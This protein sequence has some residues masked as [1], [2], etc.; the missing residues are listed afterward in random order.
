MA[1]TSFGL[2]AAHPLL[3]LIGLS[4]CDAD[5]QCAEGEVPNAALKACVVP[6]TCDPGSSLNERNE[7]IADSPAAGSD[8]STGRDGNDG[9][10]DSSNTAGGNSGSETSEA[11][12]AAPGDAGTGGESAPSPASASTGGSGDQASDGGTGGS[13]TGSSNADR[14]TITTETVT[15][16]TTSLE[17]QRALPTT[18]QNCSGTQ[19]VGWT[20]GTGCSW[21]EAKKYCETSLGDGWRLPT[22]EEFATIVDLSFSNPSIDPALFPP[23]KNYFWTATTLTLPNGLLVAEAFAGSSDKGEFKQ[24]GLD[25]N[26]GRVRCVRGGTA[27]AT[28]TSSSSG[29]AATTTGMVGKYSVAADTVTDTSTSLTWQR[30]LPASYPGCSGTPNTSGRSG[31]TWS[32]ANAYCGS[33][34][35]SGWRLPTQDEFSAIVDTAYANPSLDPKVFPPDDSYFWTTT[36]TGSSAQAFIGSSPYGEF[37][38]IDQSLSY[39]R[40]RCVR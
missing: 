19:G 28:D 25:E 18:Y 33:F 5:Q 29:G 34:M 40:P 30:T 27:D 12:G 20:T 31:C 36:T 37:I 11:G 35:G 10:A 14:Y 17:W 32:E 23:D 7:C 22:K 8:G 3:L 9:S 38:A 21:A 39:P 13:P 24:L 2:V 26:Y 4:A 16:H 6:K 1:R 15:D